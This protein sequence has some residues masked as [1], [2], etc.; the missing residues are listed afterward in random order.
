[1]P[2]IGLSISTSA[3]SFGTSLSAPIINAYQQH[4][5]PANTGGLD[6]NNVMFDFLKR[7]QLV[8][9]G[10]ASGKTRRRRASNEDAAQPRARARG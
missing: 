8:K 3:T 7:S 2:G 9:R 10:L 5:S 1:M 6:A 4:R